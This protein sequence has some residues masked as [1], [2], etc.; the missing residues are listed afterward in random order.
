MDLFTWDI[1][2]DTIDNYKY[3]GIYKDGVVYSNKQKR[4]IAQAE[5]WM[6][7]LNLNLTRNCYLGIFDSTT[8]D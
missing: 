2:L 6:T 8:V 3:L 7:L 4:L 1:K 5:I